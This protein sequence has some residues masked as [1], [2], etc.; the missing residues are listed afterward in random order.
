MTYASVI[1]DLTAQAVD[2]E[3]TYVVP[4]EFNVSPGDMVLVPFGNKRLEGFVTSVS[5]TTD[6]PQGKLKP[7]R[8]KLFEQ[9]VILPELLELAGYMRSRYS[10]TNADALRSMIPAQL[11]GG[12]IREKTVRYVTLN[13]DYS[14]ALERTHRA[15]AQ[16]KVVEALKEGGRTSAEL[17]SQFDI[18]PAVLSALKE[19][20]VIGFSA[21]AVRREPLHNDGGRGNTDPVLTDDQQFVADRLI[22]E[23]GEGQTFLLYG[24]TGSGKTEVYI[25]LIREVIKQQKSAIILVPEISLTPQ[26]VGWFHAR[27]GDL[28]A[29]IHSGLSAGERFDEWNRIRRGE[30]K[31]VIGARSAVF[32]PVQQLGAII[33]DEEH[34]AA[35]ISER[36]PRYDAR[37]IA[38]W[39]VQKNS[40]VLVLGSATPSI[41][42]FMRTSPKVRPENRIQLLELDKRV[43]NRPMPQT[44]LI[45]MRSELLEGNRSIFSS[46]LLKEL[47][48]C[49]KNGQQAILFINRRGHSSFV[50]CRKCGYVVKCPN[51]DVA[52]TY[53][54]NDRTLKC[55]YCLNE[56]PLPGTCPEC[57]SRF[58]KF[59]G[60]GTQKIEQEVKNFIP[61]AR[62]IR[63]DADTTSTKDAHAKLLDSFAKHEADVLVGTQMIAKG[64]DF[65]NVTLV[66]AVAAD[67]TLNLP[68]FRSAERTFQLLTQVAGRAGRD[69]LPG[70][71]IIQTYTPDHYA[72]QCAL[73]QDYRAFYHSE[74]LFR[75]RSM[76]PPFTVI[77]RLVFLSKDKCGCQ[78][79]ANNA[80]NEFKSQVEEL[81]LAGTV[82][83]VTVSEAPIKRIREEFRFQLIAKLFSGSNVDLIEGVMHR[84]EQK[85]D[86]SVKIEM[87][88]NPNNL[89]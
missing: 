79:T 21:H 25:R 35:Y 73:R 43:H 49:M 64:L 6:V 86:D 4:D 77:A 50:S 52:M 68:D 69:K 14:L 26:T 37:D 47:K 15:P 56:I 9:S 75:K 24:V 85:S 48:Q 18:A 19:K 16:R 60:A 80:L 22:K 31:V 62:V 36:S 11:R 58:I 27:F 83:S 53:H 67:T 2:R 44:Q 34:E 30:A 40:G 5:E 59:F 74:V 57:A 42:S 29:V 63:M 8:K 88:I 81:G 66:G 3:F 20:G 70:K 28:S 32:A 78:N 17:F 12:R 23:M 76:Y 84:I 61:E 33:V 1:V 13:V 54:L 65:P 87:E 89:F 55:H 72:I 39:R 10:C 46:C 51:C 45:D 82:L 41:Q 71:V 38:A 7:I